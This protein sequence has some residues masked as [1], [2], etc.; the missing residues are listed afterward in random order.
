MQEEVR[1]MEYLSEEEKRGSSIKLAVKLCL[2]LGISIGLIYLGQRY[3]RIFHIGVEAFSSFIAFSILLMALNTHEMSKNIPFLFMGIAYGFAGGFNIIHMVSSNGMGFFPGETTNLSMIFSLI[4]RFMVAVSILI[5]C[6]LFYRSYK[7]ITPFIS[8]I[9][10][11]VFSAAILILI[12]LLDKFPQCYVPGYGTTTFK[13]LMDYV[14]SAITLISVIILFRAKKYIETNIFI[15]L[16]LYL[17]ASIICNILLTFY[18]TQQEI[19]NVLA[20]I[21]RLYSF[22]SIYRAIVKVGL[23]TPYKLLFNE[24]SQ[25][26]NSLIL[27]DSEL[28]KTVTELQKE[29][30]LRRNIEEVLLNNEA[31]Y[32]LL[33]KNSQDTIIIYDEEKIMFANESAAVLIGLDGSEKLLGKS[34][35]EL[36]GLSMQPE[37]LNAIDKRREIIIPSYETEIKRINDKITHVEVTSA[38]IIYQ[39]KPA[40]MSLVRDISPLKQVEKM[41]K[42]FEEDKKLL[43]ETLEFNRLITEFFSDFSHELRTPLNVVLSALQVLEIEEHKQA[44]EKIGEKRNRYIKVIKQNCYRLLR[45][46]NNLIDIS[47]FDSGYITLQLGNYNIVNIVEEITLSVVEYIENKGIKFTF[48]TNVE[49]KI[50]SCDPEKIERIMMN[51]LSNAAKF[52]NAGDEISVEIMDQGDDIQIS[53]RDT[54]VGI[55]EDKLQVIFERFS[56]VDNSLSK[57]HEGS[58]IGLSLVKALVEMHGGS[59]NVKS[60]PDHGSEFIISIPVRVVNSSSVVQSNMLFN[61]NAERINIEFSDI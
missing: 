61:D 18:V 54:G 41:E 27:K 23:K 39:N 40:I 13:I 8:I 44:P 6:R 42:V 60:S 2:L 7:V 33:I 51:L 45:L 17:Y 57:S 50:L 46:I 11:S 4:P 47:K 37:V 38:Y 25:K 10:F 24:L 31:C 55:P 29:N 22:Y 3:Y 15:L 1:R 26:N 36:F 12:F 59:I 20:H 35:A 21:L 49:E 30:E 19:T 56:Q 52:T 58:G 34:A 48:D 16:Q 9:G 5:C 53:V 32:E 14:I 43:N 28:K